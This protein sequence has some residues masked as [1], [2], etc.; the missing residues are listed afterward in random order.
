M[1]FNRE[2]HKRA[3]GRKRIGK[4]NFKKRWLRLTNQE[5]SYHKQKGEWSTL[6]CV[7]L[8]SSLVHDPKSFVCEQFTSKMWVSRQ[9]F[10]LA[11]FVYGN[12][13]EITWKASL[14]SFGLSSV[15]HSC[16]CSSC[17][18]SV[19]GQ[20]WMWKVMFPLLIYAVGFMAWVCTCVNWCRWILWI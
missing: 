18:C 8:N 3:Q 17:T 5:L 1:I 19:V 9:L 13:V 7:L 20:F 16:L 6:R 4:K 15:S 10:L 11:D 2:V 14:D 12:G